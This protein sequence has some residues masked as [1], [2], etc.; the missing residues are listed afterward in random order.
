M[1]GFPFS[2]RLR[3]LFLVIGL[4]V[5]GQLACGEK[6]TVADFV[7][8]SISGKVQDKTNNSLIEGATVSTQPVT[9]TQTTDVDGRFTI[10]IEEIA[11][12][13]TFEVIVTADGYVSFEKQIQVNKGMDTSV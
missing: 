5:V 11:V 9:T 4:V 12:S 3:L 6:P 7:S 2:N 1:V 10:E 13:T 8:T